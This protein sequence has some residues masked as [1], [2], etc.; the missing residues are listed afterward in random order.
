MNDTQ[1]TTQSDDLAYGEKYVA[2]LDV[3]GFKAQVGY[4]DDNPEG[5]Q[6]IVDVIR[7]LRNTLGK[8]PT[9]DFEFT[10]FSDCIVLSGACSTIGLHSVMWGAVT[11]SNNLLNR[12]V[13]L[14]GG[15]TRGNVTHTDDIL[16]GKAMIDAYQMDRSGSP[17]RISLTRQVAADAIDYIATGMFP[18][19]VRQDDFDLTMMLHT[20][21]EY[22][23]FNPTP[24]VGHVNLTGPAFYISSTISHNAGNLSLQPS[25]RAKWRWLRNYWNA[26]VATNGILP[27]AQ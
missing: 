11:L 15:I 12:G 21:L 14:R 16:Y 23:H 19:W 22:E 7:I 20:L 3:L 17:P 1:V 24:A 5:R 27:K 26:A 13:L 8:F 4:A 2:F 18:H 10:H 25:I 9:A 6:Y